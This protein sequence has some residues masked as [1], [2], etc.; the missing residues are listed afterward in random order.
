[1]L[2]HS[3]AA[4]VNGEV[5]KVL[6]RTCNREHTYKHGQAPKRKQSAK[7]SAFEQV[8]A[9]ILGPQSEVAAPEKPPVRPHRRGSAAKPSHSK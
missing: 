4:L 5:V 3:I 1:M 6:C 8:L 9:G 7:P 2:D